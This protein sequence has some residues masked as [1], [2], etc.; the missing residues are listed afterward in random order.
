M[1]KTFSQLNLSSVEHVWVEYHVAESILAPLDHQ[2]TLK[3]A[4]S[5][6]HGNFRYIQIIIGIAENCSY[7]SYHFNF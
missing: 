3:S 7:S 4:K 6:S 5:G 2:K 1:I